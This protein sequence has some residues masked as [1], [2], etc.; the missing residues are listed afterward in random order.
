MNIKTTWDPTIQ[1]TY[2]S[3]F[4]LLINLNYMVYLV[5]MAKDF[6]LNRSPFFFATIE[7]SFHSSF[8]FGIF[9]ILH[10]SNNF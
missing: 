9:Q 5:C 2:E 8:I 3:G 1:L 10:N 7:I 6:P 4:Y